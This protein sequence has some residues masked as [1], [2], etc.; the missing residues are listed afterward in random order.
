MLLLYPLKH[1]ALNYLKRQI[2]SEILKKR[3]RKY[4]P[5]SAD[6]DALLNDVRNVKAAHSLL[7]LKKQF[8]MNG[9]RATC[10]AALRPQHWFGIKQ[11]TFV[12]IQNLVRYLSLAV[13]LE[14]ELNQDNVRK[15]TPLLNALGAHW[16]TKQSCDRIEALLNETEHKLS[17]NN[18]FT[19][20][21]SR[22]QHAPNTAAADDVVTNRHMLLSGA[23]AG[24]G[25]G[26]AAAAYDAE[27]EQ[28]HTPKR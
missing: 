15:R 17:S 16:T 11:S 7:D 23:G 28:A 12:S 21:W 2:E 19:R 22:A 24:Q 10:S 3:D 20:V 25:A 9:E 6:Y 1:T 26:A 5:G 13:S 8:G 4:R 18:F 14:N 27:D